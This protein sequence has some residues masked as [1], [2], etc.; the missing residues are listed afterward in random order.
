M[1]T[2][3]KTEGPLAGAIVWLIDDEEPIRV[4]GERVLRTQGQEELRTFESCQLAWEEL[5][6]SRS[7]NQRLPDIIVS[8]NDMKG[9]INGRELH[10]RITQMPLEQKPTFVLMSGVPIEEAELQKEGIKSFISKPFSLDKL[11]NTVV[12]AWQ[13][14]KQP[15][16]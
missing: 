7:E 8:D 2:E 11:R 6:K 5:E 13:A 1:E 10:L 15:R 12:S 3:E 16:E 14:H 4:L 9:G